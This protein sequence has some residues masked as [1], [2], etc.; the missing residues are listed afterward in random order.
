MFCDMLVARV[1]GTLGGILPSGLDAAN[2]ILEEIHRL[3]LLALE[4]V[5]EVTLEVLVL[6]CAGGT[7][8]RRLAEAERKRRGL[9]RAPNREELLARLTSTDRADRVFALAQ[10]AYPADYES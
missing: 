2:R 9:K 1:F 7:P 10:R 8:L 4:T 6:C 5:G 3:G